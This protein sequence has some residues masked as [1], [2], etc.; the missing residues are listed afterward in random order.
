MDGMVI[1]NPFRQGQRWMTEHLA[2]G[3]TKGRSQVFMSQ[4][5]GVNID[6]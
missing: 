3:H 1:M 5:V 2:R 4:R 6:T